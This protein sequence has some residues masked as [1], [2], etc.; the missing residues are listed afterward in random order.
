M[1]RRA[2]KG[3]ETVGGQ[4]IGA[5]FIALEGGIDIQKVVKAVDKA[6]F[7]NIRHAAF[8]I[9]KSAKASI[10]KSPNASAPGTPPKTR[11]RGGKNLRGAIFTNV[12]KDEAV[13]GPRF[14]FVGESGEAHEF[15]KEYEG[16]SFAIRSFMEPA[17]MDA[18]PRFAKDWQGSVG[19]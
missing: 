12:Q 19:Q 10:K 18:L 5:E 15:G 9:S 14:S 2:K 11:A 6:K 8:S 1:T 17:L 4:F 13:I 7:E 3:G 16:D